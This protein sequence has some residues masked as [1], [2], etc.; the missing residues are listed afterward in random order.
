M[1]KQKIKT[2]GHHNRTVSDETIFKVSKEIIV[3]F[4]EVGRLTPANFDDTF[5]RVYTSVR[6]T[7]RS[8]EDS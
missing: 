8:G 3:K 6:E 1:G 5:K 4:I 2:T 7:V